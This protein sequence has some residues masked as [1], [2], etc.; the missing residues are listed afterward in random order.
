MRAGD[1]PRRDRGRK[2]DNPAREVFVDDKRAYIRIH[3]EQ[4]MILRRQTI[5]ELGPVPHERPG[6]GPELFAG[7]IEPRRLGPLLFRKKKL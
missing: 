4:E 2:V 7:Q 3:T 6:S 5:E 1:P